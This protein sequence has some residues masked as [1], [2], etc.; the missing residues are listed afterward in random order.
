MKADVL[1]N[2]STNTTPEVSEIGGLVERPDGRPAVGILNIH[3]AAPAP[4]TSSLIS[5]T[6]FIVVLSIMTGLYTL[7]SLAIFMYQKEV[8][9]LDPS[10]IQALAGLLSVPWGFKFVFGYTYDAMVP[11]IRKAKNLVLILSVVRILTFAAM[12]YFTLSTLT[13]F[14]LLLVCTVCGLYENIVSECLLVIMTKRENERNPNE[15]ANHLPIF[16]AC[17]GVGQLVGSFFGG[18]IISALSIRAAFLITAFLPVIMIVVCL[19]YD[20]PEAEPRPARSFRHEW[21]VVKSLVMRDKVIPMLLFFGVIN[22]T[23]NFDSITTF[24]QTDYLKFTMD[25]LANFTSFSTV[26][27]IAGMTLYSLYLR[28]FDPRK[29]FMT[30]SFLLWVVNVSFMLVVLGYVTQWGWSVKLFCLLN[31]GTYSLISEMN[32]M[33]IIAIWC[34]ICPANLEATSITLL[35]A[36]INFTNNV[37]V[38]LGVLLMWALNIEGQQFDRLWI[39]L[40][41]QNAYLIVAIFIILFV[42]FPDP[43]QRHEVDQEIMPII[44]KDYD[45]EFYYKEK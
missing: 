18:R 45:I 7:C 31:F 33:P 12:Y 8:L 43:S 30:T 44:S 28:K 39:L 5:Q 26:C 1:F 19:L 29:F 34:S 22:A 2:K 25:D 37:G 24:Y 40:T 16:F 38:Y 15:K 32:M 4:E 42:P 14:L 35:T 21:E 41:I 13:F 20:E 36:L 9:K 27:Y 3:P 6:A 10:V 11:L 23:P 17:R